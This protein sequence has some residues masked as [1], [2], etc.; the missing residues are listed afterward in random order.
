VQDGH[1]IYEYFPAQ[2]YAIAIPTTVF[3]T[4]LSIVGIFI[5]YVFINESGKRKKR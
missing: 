2:E 5:G 3:V 4:L 1:P